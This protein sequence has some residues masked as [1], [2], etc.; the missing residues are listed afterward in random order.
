MNGL[1]LLEIISYM[2]FIFSIFSYAFSFSNNTF[3][4]DTLFLWIVFSMYGMYF[5]KKKNKY[6][7]MVFIVMLSIPFIFI[8]NKTAI[9]FLAIICFFAFYIMT[10]TITKT[11]YGDMMDNF[12]KSLIIIAIFILFSLLF[13][14]F[15]MLNKYSSSFMIIYVISSIILMRNLRYFEYNS[16]FGKINK[17]SIIYSI[18]IVGISFVLGIEEVRHLIATGIKT[19]FNFIVDVLF[20]ILYWVIIGIGYLGSFISNKV[21]KVITNED[22][23]I[24][25]HDSPVTKKNQDMSNVKS[26]N[27]EWLKTLLKIL[28]GALIIFLIVYIIIKLFKRRTSVSESRE[29][30][31]EEKE[32]IYVKEKGDKINSII[33][34]KD[35]NDRIRFYYRKFL[36]KCKRE[37]MPILDSD[38]T[39]DV[40]H[41]ANESYDDEALEKIREEYIKV[42]YGENPIDND[43]YDKFYENYKKIK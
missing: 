40:N 23:K 10:K 16:N 19:G 18:L 30:Y 29:E 9:V 36:K 39:L 38:T 7:Y 8:R 4:V 17:L 26:V 22:I 32:F 34:P 35:L 2:A 33:R 15:N 11:G 37:G 41:K 12:N 24:E 28:L 5:L 3:I 21:S 13:G 43:E 20:K 31:E 14:K 25:Q 1:V 6:W 27:I 42:R